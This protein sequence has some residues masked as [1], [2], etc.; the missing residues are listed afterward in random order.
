MLLEELS[1]IRT[2]MGIERKRILSAGPSITDLEVELVSEAVRRGWYE[3]M[4]LHTDQFVNEFKE[5][6]GVNDCLPVTNCTSALHLAMLGLDL[7]PGDEVIVPDITWVASVAPIHYVG[8]TPVFAD[9]DPVNWCLSPESFEKS[10]TPRTKAVVVVDTYGNMPDWDSILGIAKKHN[11]DVIED[12]A[13]AL[14]A[15]Y[16][17]KKAGS[18]GDISC[19]S[20]NV[21]KLATSGQGGVISARNP[22]VM[23]KARSMA[24]HGMVSYSEKA[25]WSTEIGYNYQW[26]NL[27]AALGL[28]QLRRMDELL[29]IK[30]QA[31]EWYK[32]RLGHIPEITLNQESEGSKSTL[33]MVNT[34]LS[35]KYK[36]P[37][38]VLGKAMANK[39]IDTR[40]FF[41]PVSAQ[42]AYRKYTQGR[43]YANLNPVA[44]GTSRYGLSLPYAMRLTEEDVDYVCETFVEVLENNLSNV[45]G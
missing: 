8:A 24:H 41:Y 25:F 30:R 39:G 34:I 44:Y 14:G 1:L 36:I 37:K 16:K 33:W 27:Q 4:R 2:N 21:T 32:K 12:T 11:L 17:G 42:P 29:F 19:F 10:I 23:S 5:Y 28:A 22:D 9:I 18:F 7:G 43:D 45:E 13:E 35:G 3:D 6:V 20:L 15:E 40:P 31:F 26:S 38:E